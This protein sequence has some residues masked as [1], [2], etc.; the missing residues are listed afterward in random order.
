MVQTETLETIL[1]V[2]RNNSSFYPEPDSR[3]GKE[4]GNKPGNMPDSLHGKQVEMKLNVTL[5]SKR[6]RNM[7]YTLYTLRGGSSSAGK[8]GQLVIGK[9]LVQIPGPG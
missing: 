2:P 5:D 3:A 4:V 6:F 9:S 8:A 1:G 7:E